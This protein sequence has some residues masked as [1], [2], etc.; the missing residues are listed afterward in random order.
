MYPDVFNMHRF[1]QKAN[2]IFLLL[3]NR[4]RVQDAERKRTYDK[5]EQKELNA[6]K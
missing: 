5:L 4:N 2:I 3:D 6:P 1:D